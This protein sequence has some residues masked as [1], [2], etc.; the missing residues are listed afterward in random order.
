M[1]RAGT[2]GWHGRPHKHGLVA[3]I[4]V[5]LAARFERRQ[6]DDEEQLDEIGL[7]AHVTQ[8][9]GCRRGAAHIDEGE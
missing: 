2:G 5:Y 7:E 4:V 6:L 9:F 8:M 1:E 3:D